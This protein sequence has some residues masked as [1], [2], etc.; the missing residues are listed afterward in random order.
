LLPWSLRSRKPEDYRGAERGILFRP[1]EL[2]AFLLQ[3]NRLGFADGRVAD[4]DNTPSGCTSQPSPVQGPG[5]VILDDTKGLC[6]AT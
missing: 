5:G 3:T 2:P 1:T 6:A 4:L